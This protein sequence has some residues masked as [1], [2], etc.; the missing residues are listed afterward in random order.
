MR[1]FPLALATALVAGA[2][3]AGITIDGNLTDLGTAV[4][5]QTESM[6]PPDARLLASGDEWL[7][8]LY[9]TKDASNIYIGIEGN[10]S[11]GTH[12]VVF[13]DSSS[14]QGDFPHVLGIPTA[15]GSGAVFSGGD[16]VGSITDLDEIDYGFT[17]SSNDTGTGGGAA[18]FTV[19]AVDYVDDNG[20]GINGAED[21]G[22]NDSD[23]LGT[24]TVSGRATEVSNHTASFTTNALP[25]GGN[26]TFAYSDNDV[27]GLSG[28]RHEGFEIRIPWTVLGITTGS[29][30][31]LFA[32][33]TT[34]SGSCS[35]HVLPP[36][37]GHGA[38]VIGGFGWDFLNDLEG[39]GGGGGPTGS[40]GTQI[41]GPFA[42]PAELSV[43]SAD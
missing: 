43:F 23:P 30:V 18:T 9:F 34:A 22:L 33:C 26:V 11:Q 16:L 7:D 31:R 14:I 27:A 2:A 24:D 20:M 40:W 41:A 38:V 3:S 6:A 29:N 8:A 35:A 28:A 12:F 21:S 17:G 39:V 37:T 42:A 15:S 25:G 13:I 32:L 36:A 4:S 5:V 10:S 1:S 19:T